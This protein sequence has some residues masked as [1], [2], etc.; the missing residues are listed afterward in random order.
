MVKVWAARIVPLY[1]KEKYEACYQ[2]LPRWRKEKADRLRDLRAKAQSVGAWTLWM[3]IRKQ[4]GLPDD[5]VFNLSHSGEYVMCACSD[6]KN[7]QVGC[8]LEM[9]RD[10]REK[11]ARRFFCEKEYAYIIGRNSEE[12]RRQ[13]FY[14]YWVLKESFMKATR[15]G[16]S[17]DTR[18]FWIG[19]DE[20]GRPVL[21]EKPAEF[22]E[23]YHYH[24][25]ADEEIPAKMAVCTT[26]PHIEESLRIISL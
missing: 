2:E 17:L 24:E 19:W 5:A 6:R 14:R 7:V 21:K 26:D 20:E 23:H 4:E 3:M 15:R 16:M 18:A 12:E 9:V 11:V 25:Y 10:I 22:P 13:L 8:D 1:S